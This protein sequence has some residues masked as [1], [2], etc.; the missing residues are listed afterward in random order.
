M[1]AEAGDQGIAAVVQ[2]IDRSFHYDKPL[3]AVR[4][5]RQGAQF[6]LTNPDHLLAVERRADARRRHYCRRH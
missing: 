6:V 5:I 4:Y 3:K 1:A 2:G